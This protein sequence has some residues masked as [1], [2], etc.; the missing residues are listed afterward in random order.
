MRLL[1]AIRNYEGY[2]RFVAPIL[3]RVGKR[4]DIIIITQDADDYL[5]AGDNSSYSILRPMYG[6]RLTTFLRKRLR[7][8]AAYVYW[9]LLGVQSQQALDRF[10]GRRFIQKKWLSRAIS[11]MAS[12]FR[13]MRINHNIARGI[14]LSFRW[15]ERGTVEPD[16][17]TQIKEISPDVILATPA[18]YPHTW[19]IDYVKAGIQLKIPTVI[20]VASWDHLSG[21]GWLSVVPDRLFVWNDL[22]V[23]E[24]QEYHDVPSHSMVT[25][26]SPLFDWLFDELFLQPRADFCHQAQL[27][28][29]RPYI[30]W[31]ASAPGNCLDEPGVT[32]MLLQE[33]RK[34]PELDDCQI[35]IR[36]HP[37]KRATRWDDWHYPNAP[38]WSNPSFPTEEQV[39]FDLYN[40]ITHA[41]A[42][43]GLSTSVFLEAGIL[44]RPVCL[45]RNSEVVK[46]LAHN[47]SMHFA[48]LLEN[49]FPEA[50]ENEIDCARWLAG[51]AKG[52]DMGKEKRQ[53]FVAEFLRPQGRDRS[54]AQLA[55]EA[56][57]EL[58]GINDLGSQ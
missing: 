18:L 21:K 46:D 13:R 22:H 4:A 58:I 49:G 12:H 16:I 10:L 35:L 26:G 23:R 53:K 34:Y 25:V 52:H 24:A 51:I 7:G 14:L 27:D 33:M 17:I 6:G 45:L 11:V 40:S 30:L 41:S 44:D 47:K 15:L 8:F 5:A 37:S 38:V 29:R 57:L 2:Y 20:L 50:S 42:V 55:S 36:P 54:S 19:D 48:Y 39:K 32:R 43:V 9:A 31:A 1:V 3:D 28:P 56:I